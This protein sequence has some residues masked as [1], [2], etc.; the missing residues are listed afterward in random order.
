MARSRPAV[1]GALILAIMTT[2]CLFTV[3]TRHP[4]LRVL[5]PGPIDVTTIATGRQV[6]LVAHVDPER[7]IINVEVF[8]PEASLR[9]R[10]SAWVRVQ[11][12]AIATQAGDMKIYFFDG[13]PTSE[14]RF[15]VSWNKVPPPQTAIEIAVDHVCLGEDCEALTL[16][17][18]IAPPPQR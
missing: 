15:G 13:V 4:R 14:P 2:A 12:R 16:M 8:P 18:P 1:P 7:P 5:R 3:P 9:G 17:V 6:V 11:G 10:V